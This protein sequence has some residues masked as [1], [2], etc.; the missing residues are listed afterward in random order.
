MAVQ[1]DAWTVERLACRMAERSVGGMAA[2]MVDLLVDVKVVLLGHKLAAWMAASMVLL[3]DFP[4]VD[5]S[6]VP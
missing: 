2:M 3:K 5:H 1:K 6:A 4:L